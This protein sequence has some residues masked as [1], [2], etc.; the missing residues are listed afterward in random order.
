[1]IVAY[2]ITAERRVGVMPRRIGRDDVLT[3]EYRPTAQLANRSD[4]AGRRYAL[5]FPCRVRN[6]R[7][8]P[9]RPRC[10]VGEQTEDP[11]E[12]RG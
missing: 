5:S 7:A 11:L 12:R 6:Q 4:T 9:T 10:R 1:V 2:G 3:T 8:S